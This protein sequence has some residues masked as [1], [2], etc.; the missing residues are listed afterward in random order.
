M[1]DDIEKSRLAKTF[2]SNESLATAIA[3]L[4]AGL[5]SPTDSLY[6]IGLNLGNNA[7]G[8]ALS[9][10]VLEKAGTRVGHSSFYLTND[11]LSELCID[12]FPEP[13]VA[14]KSVQ[15]Y[16]TSIRQSVVAHSAL[17]ALINS[18]Y[19]KNALEIADDPIQAAPFMCLTAGINT[20]LVNGINRFRKLSKGDWAIVSRPD[21]QET[22]RKVIFDRQ[23]LPKRHQQ[24]EPTPA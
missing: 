17:F 18:I 21:A 20:R 23:I 5:T 12:K 22:R 4:A 9:R 24:E 2:N 10:M 14:L 8:I 3:S 13:A 7:A 6:I 15:K 16:G 11:A 19:I 1:G